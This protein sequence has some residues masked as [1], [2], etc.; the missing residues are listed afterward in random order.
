MLRRLQPK[1]AV[2]LKRRGVYSALITEKEYHQW[3]AHTFV[4]KLFA[5]SVKKL[6]ASLVSGGQLGVLTESGALYMWGGADGVGGELWEPCGDAIA[7]FIAPDGL[8]QVD[9]G[10]WSMVY[11]D[12][13]GTLWNARYGTGETVKLAENVKMAFRDHYS[14]LALLEDGSVLTWGSSEYGQLGNGT[15]EPAGE[16]TFIDDV[17]FEPIKIMDDVRSIS[18][19]GQSCFA[20]KE[21]GSLWRWGL[22]DHN[23]HNEAVCLT[24][25]ELFLQ[26]VKQVSGGVRGFAVKRDG[27]LWAWRPSWLNEK[28]K[29]APYFNGAPQKIMDKVRYAVSTWC[30]AVIKEDGSLWVWGDNWNGQL[31]DG[32][33]ITRHE[34]Y[35]LM[36][37]VVDVAC[38]YGWMLIMTE[39]GELWETGTHEGLYQ[40]SD[41]DALRA[42]RLPHRVMEGISPEVENDAGF[43]GK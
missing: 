28:G 29:A 20:I 3:S 32:T 12:A 40:F 35:K 14:G 42:S 8:R 17:P 6:V 30:F 21:D 25:P 4:N 9:A 41:E 11:I 1:G 19:C 22:I 34:P 33:D 43:I 38:G 26:D 36:D 16:K 39:S 13:D 10:R 7:K 27:S 24:E 2:R 31:G 37:N 18:R 15:R 5:G 23:D